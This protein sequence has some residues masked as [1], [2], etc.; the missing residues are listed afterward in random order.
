MDPTRFDTLIRGLSRAAAPVPTR[1]AV[2]A[3]LAAAL[4]AVGSGHVPAA[5][6]KKKCKGGTL[7]CNKVCIDP[8]T[9]VS[10]CGTCGNVC[11]Q[12]QSCDGGTCV[13]GGGGDCVPSCGF[14]TVCEG[15][16]C[17]AAANICAGPTGICN[18]DPTP[19]GTAATGETCGCEA[20]VEGNTFCANAVDACTTV[21]CTS[22]QDCFEVGF[23]FFCQEAKTNA[24]G[25][26]CGCGFGTAT[27]K[28]CVA[29]CDNPNVNFAQ[30]RGNHGKGRRARR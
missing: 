24:N 8:Q 5:A 16:T 9:D 4:V 30:A 22:S 14:N 20:T 17:V 6:K 10:N 21:E 2:L 18:A 23:H 12:G 7:K 28:V 11:G 1:R 29:E 15:G 3:T 13:G 19:C 25:Q 26:F 27:G